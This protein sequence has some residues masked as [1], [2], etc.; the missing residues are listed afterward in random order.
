MSVYLFVTSPQM[1]PEAI[2]SADDTWWSCSSTT[3]RGDRALVYVVGE[4]IRY[5]W[6]VLSDARRHK[7]WKFV[8]DV[9]HA[10]AFNPP[11]TL[12][13]IR[14]AVSRDEWGAPSTNFR[15]LRS[16]H[17]PDAAV[18]KVLALRDEDA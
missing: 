18:E 7:E 11:I 13:E 8:C 10:R 2:Q 5:E 3:A 15:G 14:E 4:G 1:R 9:G 12:H 17:F 6:Q 16:V